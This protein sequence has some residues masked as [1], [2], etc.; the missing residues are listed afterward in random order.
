MMSFLDKLIPSRKSCK[1][2]EPPKKAEKSENHR[3]TVLCVGTD[4]VRILLFRECEWQGRK[5]LFDSVTLEKHKKQNK[6]PSTGSPR[7]NGE[8]GKDECLSGKKTRN[9]EP[10]KNVEDDI[11]LL[12][13][14][15]FGTVAMTY[16]GPSFKVHSL[17]SPP[18]IMCTK[19]FPASEHNA[20]R[21]SRRNLEE[22]FGHTANL[23]TSNPNS[24][25]LTLCSQSLENPSGLGSLSSLRRRWLRATST[26]L[27][28]SESDD[29]F[30]MQ[31]TENPNEIRDKRHK[32]RLGLAMLVRLT[33]D[34]ERKMEERM[35]EHMALL[36]GMLDR[37]RFFCIE[38][39]NANGRTNSRGMLMAEKIYR[40]SFRFVILLLRLLMSVEAFPTPLLWHDILLNSTG[41]IEDRENTLHLSLQQMCQLLEIVDTKS[42]NFFLSTV[43]TAVL[44]YHLGWVYTVLPLQE[45]RMMEKMG[46]WYPCNP[47]WAQL[48][49]LYGALGNPTKV[50]HTVIA[51]D[52]RKVELINSILFFLSYFVRSGVVK[53]REESRC[54]SQRDVHEA[55]EIMEQAR[56]KQP[57]L[58]ASQRGSSF[59]QNHNIRSHTKRKQP[60]LCNS[61]F[62]SPVEIDS[63]TLKVS[64]ELGTLKRTRSVKSNLD[65]CSVKSEQSEFKFPAD[66][67]QKKDI[68]QKIVSVKGDNNPRFVSDKVRLVDEESPTTK[69]E[70]LEDVSRSLN[71]ISFVEENDYLLKKI[72]SNEENIFNGN[73]STLDE[74]E[75]RLSAETVDETAGSL[76]R[77]KLNLDI[78]R[79]NGEHSEY[80]F[81]RKETVEDGNSVKIRLDVSSKVKLDEEEKECAS[82][83]IRLDENH[84]VQIDEDYEG[85]ATSKAK[86][87]GN[88]ISEEA[89]LPKEDL[90]FLE[91][92]NN[93]EKLDSSTENE[94]SNNVDYKF[95]TNLSNDRFQ[96]TVCPNK[97]SQ[98]YFTLGEEEKYTKS[99]SRLRSGYNCQCSYTFTR[100]PSTSAQL[101]EGVLR[102][103]LQRNFP[104]S[105]KSMQPPPVSGSSGNPRSLGFCLKCSGQGYGNPR[106]YDGS[107]QLLETPTN[108]TE[109]L[110][111][112]G[113]SSDRTVNDRTVG[114]S[115][116]NSLETL[117]EANNVVELPM[118]R[119]KKRLE[120][121]DVGEETG[122]TKTLLQNKVSNDEMNVGMTGTNYTWGLAMQGLVKKKRKRRKKSI[123]ANGEENLSREEN[124]KDWWRFMR[125]EVGADVRFPIIDQ[126]I[127]EAL[128]ILG[129][130]DTWQVGIMSNNTPLHSPPLTVGMSRLVSEMLEAFTYVW[131]KYRSPMHCVEILEGKLRE[132]FMRSEA[133]AE[134]LMTSDV[135]DA[136]IANVTSALDLDAADIPLLLAVATTHSPQVAQRFGL[137]LT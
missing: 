20:C 24:A 93:E 8:P 135:C 7:S 137:T 39:S 22:S 105:S 79:L 30:G 13:E 77:S 17:N 87:I 124:E 54:P 120:K 58:F 40:A 67:L 19:V 75:G 104:E 68:K 72:I 111:T 70:F 63:L 26:S 51:G 44:T 52:P 126:P 45:R 134:M 119:S 102:K 88:D 32:T 47:L 85:Y 16:K 84:K 81:P 4:Q 61:N 5:L 36:E 112:C 133:L 82:I 65:T 25:V 76:D 116:S 114:L 11:S 27:S 53:K 103:I 117:M 59:E 56:L 129:D 10:E 95:Y 48:G 55:I 101:P 78:C 98:V 15:V 106:G 99:L 122:F 123:D 37:L 83:K 34:H 132:M 136:N 46:K 109:V 130:L 127:S 35:L 97:E 73:K 113:S 21:K 100:V 118:P 9:F 107:K 2:V 3:K 94:E 80:K 60:K 115:R 90:Q 125:E 14:M 38:A 108:A 128:C 121:C 18:C 89:R 86:I 28:R 57:E 42:T 12:S 49:D 64:T 6:C 66:S 33:R 74:Q 23:E 91:Q 71:K 43:V 110:R 92:S 69:V 1:S 29:A 31:W 41:I 50:A 96:N 131:R 62:N